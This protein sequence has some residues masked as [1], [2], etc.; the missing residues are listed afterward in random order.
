MERVLL[1]QHLA[2]AEQHVALGELHIAKQHD[3]II[4]KLERDG[5]DSTFAKTLLT[6]FLETQEIHVSDRDR[7]REEINH[8][9]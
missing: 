3:E 9:S 5:Y 8:L 1:E 4:A 6:T 2:Q 7:L